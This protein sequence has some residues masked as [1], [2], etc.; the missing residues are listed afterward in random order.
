MGFDILPMTKEMLRS[1]PEQFLEVDRVIGR[2]FWVIDNFLVELPKKWELSSVA[3]DNG[4]LV[5]FLVASEKN[6]S[7]HIHRLAVGSLWQSKGVGEALVRAL[8]EK[9]HDAHIPIT[10]NVDTHNSR[11][12]SFYV[13]MGFSAVQQGIDKIEM[14]RLSL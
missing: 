1:N 6:A 11:A 7:I 5:G 10:L 13:R 2:D 3:L 12:V 9:V 8:L 4:F 14:K